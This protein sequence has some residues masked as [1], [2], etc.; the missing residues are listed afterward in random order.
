MERIDKECTAMTNDQRRLLL[1]EADSEQLDEG[2][3]GNIWNIRNEGNQGNIGAT[4][5]MTTVRNTFL[6]ILRVSKKIH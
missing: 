6:P 4:G 2:S 1:R 3:M 5:I